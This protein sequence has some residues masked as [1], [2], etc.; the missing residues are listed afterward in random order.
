MKIQTI[1][2]GVGLAIQYEGKPEAVV[3]VFGEGSTNIGY[4]HES[5]NLAAV[6]NLPVVFL[7]ENNQ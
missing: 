3:C 6:W 4:F 5:V 2:T 7:V 1:R